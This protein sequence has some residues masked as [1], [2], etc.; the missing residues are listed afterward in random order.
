M[1]PTGTPTAG[2]WLDLMAN[3][4]LKND[5]NKHVCEVRRKGVCWCRGGA[6]PTPLRTCACLCILP[7]RACKPPELVSRPASAVSNDTQPPPLPPRSQVQFVHARLLL[8]RKQMGGHDEYNVYRSASELIAV[9][10]AERALSTCSNLS[11]AISLLF[12][13][14]LSHPS[15][16]TPHPSSSLLTPH[17]FP[18]P[19]LLLPAL[20]LP[21]PSSVSLPSFPF[22]P[23]SKPNSVSAIPGGMSVRCGLRAIQENRH[24]ELQVQALR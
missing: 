1:T 11:L 18:P 7:T 22:V 19:L 9:D 8:V 12:S 17:F 10:A 15:S 20:I 21:P 3:V 2:G 24:V 23:R 6:C 5:R 4:T 13:S 14:L 16:L